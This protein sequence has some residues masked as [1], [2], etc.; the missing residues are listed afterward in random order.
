M[1]IQEIFYLTFIQGHWPLSKVKVTWS[2]AFFIMWPMYLQSLKLLHPMVKEMHYQENIHY[3]P[4]PQCQ[5]GQGHMKCCLVP[6]TSCGLCTSKVWYCYILRLRRRCIYKKIHYHTKCCPVPSTSCD[7]CTY[8]VWSYYVKGL[9]GD[10]FTRK[11][12]IW[13]LTLTSRSHKLLP[14]TLYIMWLFSYKVWSCYG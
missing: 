2:I 13:L 14:S 3:W 8:R 6:S 11:F 7:L 4:W 9:G 12:N 1:H 10:A 5:G